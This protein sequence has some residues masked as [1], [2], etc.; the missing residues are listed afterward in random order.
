MS[1]I[2][3]LAAAAVLAAGLAAAAPASPAAAAACPAP[4]SGVTVVVDFTELGRGIAVG[5][6][7]GNPTTGLAALRG[8]GFD[9]SFVPRQPGFVCQIDGLPNPCND[10]PPDAYWSYWYAEPG[11]SWTYSQLG[12]GS[13]NPDPGD[14]EGWA[15]GA[16]GQPGE[17]PPEAPPQPPPPPPEDPDP[18][19][20]GGDPAPGRGEDPPARGSGSGSGTEPG[21]ERTGSPAGAGPTGAAA[22]TAAPAGPDPAGGGGPVPPG[23]TGTGSARP[24]APAA[25]TTTGPGGPAGV[26]VAAALVSVLA[27]AGFWT[28]RRRRRPALDR[29]DHEVRHVRWP[30][31]RT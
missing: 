3:R 9:D 26:L 8:A 4:D 16:G 31:S 11:G 18:P 7:P 24:G 23:A 30:G 21:P 25:S 5:C 19:A 12:A 29:R 28:A 2:G 6:A 27:G 22:A 13:R 1:R 10:G 15:F 20:G 17:A 14:V